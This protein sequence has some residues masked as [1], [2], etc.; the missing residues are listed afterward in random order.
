MDEV[1]SYLEERWPGEVID[2][3][4]NELG[5]DLVIMGTHGRRG[6][7]RALMASVAREVATIAPGGIC[8][9]IPGTQYSTPLRDGVLE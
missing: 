1:E 3:M 8:V 6:L 7:E 9:G 2:A 4:A 5:V